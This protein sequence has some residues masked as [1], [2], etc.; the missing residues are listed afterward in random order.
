[1]VS[2]LSIYD[3]GSENLQVDLLLNG[4]EVRIIELLA[5]YVMPWRYI[6]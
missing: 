5:K 2:N 3:L 1:M 4:D 6:T